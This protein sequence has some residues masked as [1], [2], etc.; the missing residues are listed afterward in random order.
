LVRIGELVTT[1][2]N[3]LNKE[4]QADIDFLTEQYEVLTQLRAMSDQKKAYDILKNLIDE[5]D[6]LSPTDEFKKSI[7]EEYSMSKQNLLTMVDDIKEALKEG[8][9]KEI[10]LAIENAIEEATKN[11]TECGCCEECDETCSCEDY[12]LEIKT[13]KK[14]LHKR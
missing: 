2:A 4:I 6:E 10:E 8:N 7:V 13:K 14:S 5:N 3:D 9:F 1:R 11:S 12:N